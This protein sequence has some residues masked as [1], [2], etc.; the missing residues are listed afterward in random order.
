MILQDFT[1]YPHLLDAICFL[2]SCALFL[3]YLSF[4]KIM[5]RRNPA[6]TIQGITA[7][8]RTA[9]VRSVMEDRKD[10]LAVQTLRNSTMAATFLASTAI[11]LTVGVLT[12][13]GQGDKLRI[14]WQALDF[15][16]SGHQSLLEVKLVIL[17]LDLFAG[18]FF[19]SSSVRL[20]NHVGYMI[21]APYNRRERVMSPSVVAAQLNRAGHH[22]SMGMRGFYSMVPLVFWIF[23]P[24]FLLGATVV[25]LAILYH[26]DRTPKDVEADYHRECDTDTC[27]ID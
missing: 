3:A 12:L 2:L 21:N 26:L 27:D 19:F 13:T 10:I 14:T 22:Y 1:E 8:A 20:Y 15:M 11:L 4:I 16:D 25:M 23:G 6:Y 18:F 7:L 5:V 24:L 9:W 17:L